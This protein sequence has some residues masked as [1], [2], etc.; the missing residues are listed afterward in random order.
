MF[1]QVLTP[2]WWLGI[3]LFLIVFPLV[4][5]FSH[6]LAGRIF[7]LSVTAVGAQSRG[8][9]SWSP[10]VEVRRAVLSSDPVVRIWIP[11]VGVICNLLL[12]ML[13]SLWL[14]SA[15]P[16]S[17]VAGTAAVVVALLHVRV[18]VDGGLGPRSDASQALRIADE[19]LPSTKAK[20][21]RQKVRGGYVLFM[22]CTL[23]MI[24]LSFNDYGNAP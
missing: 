10:F 22:M 12:T 14:W 15:T 20:R 1:S 4:H 17:A 18:L 6:A 2:Y 19:L 21:L 5:E 9:L 16:G 11:L 24:A 23:C 7:G 8:G 3:L 13:A